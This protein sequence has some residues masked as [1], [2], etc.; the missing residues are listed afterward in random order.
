MSEYAILAALIAVALVGVVAALAGPL[1]I[2]FTDAAEG[3][4]AER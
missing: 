2:F 4:D 1:E 3:M